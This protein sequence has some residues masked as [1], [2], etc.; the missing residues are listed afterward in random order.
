[1]NSSGISVCV[2]LYVF[3]GVLWNLLRGEDGRLH[4]PVET[5]TIVFA[6]KTHGGQRGPQHG[7]LD[8]VLDL[9]S[10][11]FT[12]VLEESRF[13]RVLTVMMAC[14]SGAFV[15]FMHRD[16]PSRFSSEKNPKILPKEV[17]A[18]ASA[19]RTSPSNGDFDLFGLLSDSVVAS[20][21]HTIRVGVPRLLLGR[22][23][24]RDQV[25]VAKRVVEKALD[26]R[27]MAGVV[28]GS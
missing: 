14:H 7:A 5:A 19:P 28:G 13:A 1:M 27:G 8:G 17:F 6:G 15:D 3:P 20:V 21:A 16:N 18:L 23:W 9:D 4:G 10:Q 2:I 11:E 22:S 26:V 25:R 24:T 12:T